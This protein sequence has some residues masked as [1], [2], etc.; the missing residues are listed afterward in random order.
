MADVQINEITDPSDQY[1]NN[2]VP[3]QTRFNEQ[4][5]YEL[6]IS[7]EFDKETPKYEEPLER[8]CKQIDGNLFLR[9]Y[10]IMCLRNV[11]P[12]PSDKDDLIKLFETNDWA[13]PANIKKFKE[14]YMP[15]QAVLCYTRDAFIYERLNNALRTRN[16]NH[17]LSFRFIFQ[18]ICNQLK[19]L[20]AHDENNQTILVYR[21][22][23]ANPYECSGSVSSLLSEIAY[24][25]NN[26][27]FNIK[28]N[29][30]MAVFS[31]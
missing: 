28:G 19:E 31:F 16:M 24:Y 14:T 9:F 17:L 27:L 21:G 15:S 30:C 4:L 26:F 13:T 7:S 3:Q 29:N 10:L 11:P 23:V 22:Q 2:D 20:N 8:S 12:F 6:S 5:S 18:D 1:L 25:D